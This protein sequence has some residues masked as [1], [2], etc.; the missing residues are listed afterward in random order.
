MIHDK[1][2]G[3]DKSCKKHSGKEFLADSCGNNEDEENGQNALLL[4]SLHQGPLPHPSKLRDYND[5]ISNGAERIMQMAENE[6]EA[7][8]DLERRKLLIIEEQNKRD[9]QFGKRGQLCA[10]AIVPDFRATSLANPWGS[11]VSRGL[12][13]GDNL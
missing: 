3:D 8:I 10:T 12:F 6:Q 1:T 9:G 4:S 7:N 11:S 2:E 13:F 5:I